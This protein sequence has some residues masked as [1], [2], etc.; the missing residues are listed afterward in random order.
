V[1]AWKA[2]TY[3]SKPVVSEVWD[4]DTMVTGQAEAGSTVEV[5]VNGAVV[6]S[7]VSDTDSRFAIAI[8]AQKAGVEL[9]ITATDK[10]GLLSEA[11]IVVVK[12]TATEKPVVTTVPEKG[13]IFTNQHWY[14]FDD[15]GYLVTGWQN[16]GGKWYY[17]DR[18]NVMITG[19][20]QLGAT[21]YYLQS[22][23]AMKTG[24][25]KSGSS[26]Y[27]LE[28][29]GAM[30]TG[31]L[32]SGSSWYFLESSGVM[33]TG[34]LK[35]GSSWYFLNGSGAMMMG[36]VKVGS[37]WYY[38]YSDGRM[39]FNTTIQGYKLGASGAWVK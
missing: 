8:P 38:F 27:F 32:K 12:G 6:G 33:K 9:V 31:W 20:M 25:L 29:N 4:K 18:N 21:W 2:L 10:A 24:W 26:W 30:K 5:K 15:K 14:Y 13:W 37:S 39:A 34:W 11:A 28:S 1:N 3:N 22:S 19:W 35:S 23:G 36:W 7:G 17:F 16:I